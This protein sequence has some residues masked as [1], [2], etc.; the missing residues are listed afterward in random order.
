MAHRHS[1]YVQE[2]H[3]LPGVLRSASHAPPILITLDDG[4]RSGK[5]AITELGAD[6]SSRT[7]DRRNLN[8][9]AEVNRLALTNRSG[10]ALVLIAGEM[11]LGGR[12]DGS[13]VTIA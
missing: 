6:G 7:I 13:L 3:Y 4:L 8:S 9:S 2:S 10:K 5:V 11:I 1:V 12:Q